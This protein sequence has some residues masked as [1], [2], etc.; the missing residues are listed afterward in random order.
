MWSTFWIA[1]EFHDGRSLQEHIRETLVEKKSLAGN[2][3]FD[4]HMGRESNILSDVVAPTGNS[5]CQD[6]DAVA[7]ARPFLSGSIN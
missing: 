4:K 6:N 3:T 5:T 1:A 2:M 7:D